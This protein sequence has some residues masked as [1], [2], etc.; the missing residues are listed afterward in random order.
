[1]KQLFELFLLLLEQTK[2]DGSITT[3]Q[4]VVIRYRID[5]FI[6]KSLTSFSKRP[7]I[8]NISY[9]KKITQYA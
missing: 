3:K 4:L 9:L 8:E 5:K 7:V 1:M 6:I 2:I